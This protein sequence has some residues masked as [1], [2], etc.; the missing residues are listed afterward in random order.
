MALQRI[1]DGAMGFIDMG[2]I[3]ELTLRI[4][5]GKFRK[6][7]MQIFSGDLHE[8]DNA[9]AGRIGDKS[10]SRQVQER[11][12]GRRMNAFKGP[13]GEHFGF[14]FQFRIEAVE[15]AGLA[16]SGMSCQNRGAIG[17]QVGKLADAM[18]GGGAGEN[19]LAADLLPS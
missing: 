10:I 14:Q 4:D 11:C 3:T 2:A 8:A 7:M 15:Q 1:L 5:R 9:Q 16:D 17:Q 13:G 12:G 19:Y 6:V 18:A